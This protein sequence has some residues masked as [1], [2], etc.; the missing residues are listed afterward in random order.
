MDRKMNPDPKDIAQDWM[1]VRHSV[2]QYNGTPL[3]MENQKKASVRTPEW[4]QSAVF[5]CDAPMV[6][7]MTVIAASWLLEPPLLAQ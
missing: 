1:S 2:H 7:F 5:I 6:L 4:V 3:P